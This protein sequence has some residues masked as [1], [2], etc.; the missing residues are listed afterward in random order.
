MKWIMLLALAGC[1]KRA[2][3]PED[4]GYHPY[5]NAA[6]ER[7]KKQLEDINTQHENQLDNQIDNANQQR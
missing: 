1:T 4:A 6:P 5:K 2:P 3:A 7:V